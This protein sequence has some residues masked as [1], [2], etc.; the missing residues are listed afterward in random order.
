MPQLQS[1]QEHLQ[2]EAK[3]QVGF[4]SQEKPEKMFEKT[5]RSV[6]QEHGWT[7]TKERPYQKQQWPRKEQRY[8]QN[9]EGLDQERWRQNVPGPSVDSGFGTRGAEASEA[10]GQQFPDHSFYGGSGDRRQLQDQR[11]FPFCIKLYERPNL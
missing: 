10:R 4:R 8:Q 5:E 1:G 9:K 7:Q 6:E 11:E 3:Q 2:K